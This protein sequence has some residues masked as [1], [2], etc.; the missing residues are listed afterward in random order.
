M[1]LKTGEEAGL[2]IFVVVVGLDTGGEFGLGVGDGVGLDVGDGVG[3]DVGDG[4]GLDTGDG[5]G[6]DVGDGVG[7]GTG[8]EVGLGTG[9]GGDDLDGFYFLGR[10]LHFVTLRNLG[11]RNQYLQCPH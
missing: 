10:I 9:G 7:L 4:V 5:V 11:Q 2:E 1:S 6:L 3:L 8:G